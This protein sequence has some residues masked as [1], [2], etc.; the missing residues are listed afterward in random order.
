MN[1]DPKTIE[2]KIEQIKFL[3]CGRTSEEKIQTLLNLNRSLAPFPDDLKTPSNLVAGCQS[4]LYLTS[5]FEQGIV[6]FNACA[7]ALISGGLAALLIS[8]YS[9]ETPQTILN[10]SPNFLL[11]F[12]ILSSLTP[13]RSNG[14]AHIH[15]RMKKDALKFLL[16]TPNLMELNSPPR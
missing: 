5:R 9:G 3:F 14:L 10:T 13:T 12:G 11:D 8:V 15:Q 6:F 7:D 16:S 1:I 4:I 2:K